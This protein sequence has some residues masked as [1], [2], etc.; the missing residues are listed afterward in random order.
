MHKKPANGD[1]SLWQAGV[2]GDGSLNANGD[3]SLWQAGVNGDG[4]FDWQS[5]R[6]V[7]IVTLLC[8][9]IKTSFSFV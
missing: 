8:C 6:T 3:G 2:N 4:S 9:M 7:P 1:G 5:K